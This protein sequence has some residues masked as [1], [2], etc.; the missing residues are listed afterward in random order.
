MKNAFEHE[1][2]LS[3]L[4]EELATAKT[5]I[6][7]LKSANTSW[8]NGQA[9]LLKRLTAAEQRNDRLMEL[10]ERA[11]GAIDETAGWQTLCADILEAIE[12]TE[13]GASE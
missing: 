3:A 7:Q 9:E 1:A 10:L 12:P 5:R 4:R 11:Y 8:Q 6:D 2:E 13:S